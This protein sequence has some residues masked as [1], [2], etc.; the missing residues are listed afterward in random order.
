MLLLT[1]FGVQQLLTVQEITKQDR[2]DSAT[3]LLK[4]VDSLV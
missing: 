4:L 2:F 1:G 3:T